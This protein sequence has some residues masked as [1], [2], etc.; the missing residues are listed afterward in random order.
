MQPLPVSGQLAEARSPG[1]RPTCTAPALCKSVSVTVPDWIDPTSLAFV[2]ALDTGARFQTLASYLSM[3][4]V[5]D[6]TE[7][8][9]HAAAAGSTS[10][11]RPSTKPAA[12]TLIT[13]LIFSIPSLIA[14]DSSS[15]QPR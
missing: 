9:G 1:V 5:P 8:A 13:A 15:R 6:C 12:D 7:S 10:R 3:Q 11:P 2:L 4:T 14:V